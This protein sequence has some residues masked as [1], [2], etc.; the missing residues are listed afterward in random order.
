MMEGDPVPELSPSTN[1]GFG[2][3]GV[4]FYPPLSYYCLAA[5]RAAT[6]SWHYAASLSFLFWFFLG[7]LGVYLWSKEFFGDGASF[8]AAIAYLIAP[9]HVNEV[10]NAS[11][12]AEFA[13]AGILPFCFFFISRSVRTASVGNVVGLATAS[14]ALI[15]THLPTAV[16]GSIGLLIYTL[17]SAHRVGSFRRLGAIVLSVLAALALS[18]F[19]WIKVV[20]EIDLVK[21]SGAE[22][23]GRNYDF[24]Y[25][26][27][28]SYFSVSADVY[29]D[30]FLWMSDLMFLLTIGLFLPAVIVSLVAGGKRIFASA[31]SSAT[32]AVLALAIFMATPLSAFVWGNVSFTQKVQFPFRWMV[33]INVAG[34]YF[35]A[36]SW[37][38]LVETFSGSLR[39]AA[40]AATGLMLIT[41]AFTVAQIIRP[42]I[43]IPKADLDQFVEGL[44][45]QPS[46]QCWLAVWAKE[47]AFQ[48]REL[49]TAPGR[50]AAITEW[51]SYEKRF[52]LAAGEPGAVR[53]ATFYYPQWSAEVNGRIAETL[54]GE[55]GTLNVNVPAEAASVRIFFKE[56]KIVE[57]AKIISCGL[58][59]LLTLLS[60]IL[61]GRT[62]LSY[63]NG[64]SNRK[65]V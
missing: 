55:D 38:S 20:S 26:F 60:A 63:V 16:I 7:S 30:R 3:V 2:D 48:N 47:D 39:P 53:L 8:A 21:H 12:F 31:G 33:L 11:F 24:K 64:N 28:A 54:P 52:E 14:A 4:R 42:A 18:S 37:N 17:I 25:N 50:S 13:A 19:Y 51:S 40:L 36:A 6:G 49:L 59:F 45:D 1:F 41:A 35:L 10:Y 9:Y 56:S 29:N 43:F 32:F 23:V 27:V 62:L 65:L 22:F 15:L 44:A 58:V 34:V 5:M 57:A 61:F 46:Y